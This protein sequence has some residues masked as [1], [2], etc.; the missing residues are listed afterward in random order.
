MADSA[1]RH[2]DLLSTASQLIADA[3][4]SGAAL[5]LLGGLGV[6]QR[7]ER[8]RSILDIYRAPIADIDL[9][10]RSSD[11]GRV[12]DILA[13]RGWEENA[14]WRIH[15]G[16]QRRIFYTPANLTIELYFNRLILCQE[17]DLRNEFNGRELSISVAALFLSKIQ[18]V[19]LLQKD[20]IDLVTLLIS[21]WGGGPAVSSARI[22]DVVTSDW[23]WWWTIKQNLMRIR[24]ARLPAVLSE[25]ARLATALDALENLLNAEPKKLRWRVR[26]LFGRS[27]RWYNEVEGGE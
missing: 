2:S 5:R 18:R 9:V 22:Q 4:G 8:F 16:H 6:Y 24:R 25:D 10:T 14:T 3:E 15:F 19:D 20:L 12:T 11:A 13:A 27:L 23:R 21:Y 17:L 26:A 1:T 7:C